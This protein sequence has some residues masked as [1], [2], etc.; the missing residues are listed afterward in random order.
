MVNSGLWSKIC[1]SD[2]GGT[3]K[4]NPDFQTENQD[5]VGDRR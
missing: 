2:D 3:K 4:Y 1:S 5:Q